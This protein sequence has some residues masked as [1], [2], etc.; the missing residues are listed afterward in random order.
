[1]H[2]YLLSSSTMVTGTSFLGPILTVAASEVVCMRHVNATSP[3]I[4]SLMM[5]RT[6]DSGSAFAGAIRSEVTCQ[7]EPYMVLSCLFPIIVI[8]ARIR[9]RWCTLYIYSICT[10]SMVSKE[11]KVKSVFTLQ[12]YEYMNA[13]YYDWYILSCSQGVHVHTLYIYTFAIM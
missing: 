11:I 12:W 8:C 1:M 10:C 13:Q 4:V 5:F 9:E 6:M 7:T 3:S 2:D